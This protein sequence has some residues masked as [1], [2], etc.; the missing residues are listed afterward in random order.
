M[1]E[2]AR[3]GDQDRGFAVVAD[4]VNSLA[5]SAQGSTMQIEKMVGELQKGAQGYAQR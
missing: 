3:A 4:Q 5:K 2:T 1:I